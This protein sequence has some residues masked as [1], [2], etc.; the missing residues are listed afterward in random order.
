MTQDVASPRGR[1]RYTPRTRA[2]DDPPERRRI[3]IIGAGLVGLTLAIDLRRQGL[4]VLLLERSDTVSI[5]SRSICQAKRTLEI[6]DRLGVGEAIRDKGIVW[7]NGRVFHGAGELY[8]F[9]LL[10]ES[11]HKMP[12][13][14]NLQ[15]Y[16]VE[17]LLHARFAA[18]GGEVRFLN[19]LSAIEPR[20]DGA[21]LTIDTP[22]GAYRIDTEWVVSCEGARSMVRSALGLE[23]VGETFEDKFLIA[24]VK[25]RRADFPTERW[26]WFNPPFHDGQTSLLHRQ[27]DDVWRID[28]Q[29]GGEADTEA[30]KHPD[31]VRRR[32]E[33]MLGHGDFDFEWLSIYVFQCRTLERYVHGRVIFAGDS[34]HQVSPFG[35]RGGNGGVQ[36]AD[37]LGWK[38]GCVLAGSALPDL[39]ETYNEERLVA[40]RENILNSKRAT[41]FMT[42]KSKT[43]RLLRDQVLSLAARHPFARSLVNS[44]RLSVPAHLGASRL[45]TRDDAVWQTGQMGP[46]SPA[47]DAPIGQGD[48]D[49][50]FLDLLGDRFVALTTDP[51]APSVTTV[52]PHRV[53]I[54]AVGRDLTDPTGLLSTRYDLRPGSMILF[55][56]DQHIALRRRR[57]DLATL[58]AGVDR[59]LGRGEAA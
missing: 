53:D 54:V 48:R 51:A 11:G 39:L 37:N 49:M 8:G 38:L 18:L 56:P 3:V 17:T 43:S 55:R 46:G 4:P 47:A 50:F 41:D 2:L 6:W 59:A 44:G 29:L 15:Q 10:P 27:A 45:N 1:F 23:F 5:G 16:H 58:A 35:A 12:A 22:E 26:F 7:K 28:L 40:A 14:V 42:P 57:T 20:S 52:G 31:R 32:I 34:A 9:D 25:M 33:T 30:E 13:F 36:D 21:L 19:T 24:D